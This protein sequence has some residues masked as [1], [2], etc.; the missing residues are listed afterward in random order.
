LLGAVVTTLGAI[1]I[2]T[3]L[4]LMPNGRFSPRWAYIP[5]VCTI[6]LLSVGQL[7]VIGILTLSAQAV[8]LINTTLVGLVLLGGSLQ[9]YR[10]L[11][12]SD[13]IERQQTKWILFGV[14]SFVLSVIG[15]VIVFA[16]AVDI[17]DGE[18]RLLANV[19]GGFSGLLTITALP[20]AITMAILR[21]KLWD[22]DL[23]IRRTLV[24]AVLTGLLALVYVGLVLL[25]QS[26]FNLV[27]DQQSPVV[28]VISTLVIAALFAPLRQRVQ[29]F[30][31]RRFFRRKYD[32]ERVLAQFAQ[33]ARDETDLDRLTSELVRVVQET[34]QPAH[35]SVWLKKSNARAQSLQDAKF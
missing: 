28:I 8:S 4:Y 34:M 1:I 16:R 6:L 3:F 15:W 24:Y 5:L 19:V 2:V 25:L 31:D 22:I 30:I 32:A 29:A 27:S 13:P 11:R 35:V 23:I 18:P 7:E 9:I 33:T 17:P 21:Y 20:V 10:Y 12:D 26:A 14:L